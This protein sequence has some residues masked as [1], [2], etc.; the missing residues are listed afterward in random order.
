MNSRDALGFFAAPL[1]RAM[2]F[3]ERH[4]FDYADTRFGWGDPRRPAML[5]VTRCRGYAWALS[6]LTK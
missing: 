5:R 3:L 4:P 1:R 6:R 2:A